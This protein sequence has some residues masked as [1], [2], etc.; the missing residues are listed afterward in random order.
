MPASVDSPKMG[1]HG[2]VRIF[3]WH[4]VE[5]GDRRGLLAGAEIGKTEPNL[6]VALV[7]HA[8]LDALLNEADRILSASG[9]PQFL[10]QLDE[11]GARFRFRGGRRGL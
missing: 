5:R 9:A 6:G 8:L 7:G 4:R 10:T 11:I 3:L 1:D 2:V